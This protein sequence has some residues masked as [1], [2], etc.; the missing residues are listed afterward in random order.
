[1]NNKAIETL[2]VNAVKNSIVT[3][4]YLDEFIADND[5]EPSWDGFIYIYKNKNK[6]KNDIIGRVPVQVKGKF[7]RE[8]SKD[9][10]KYSVS[11]TDLKNYLNDGIFFFVVYIQKQSF[12]T[13]IYYAAL[14]PM[15]VKN[16]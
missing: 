8:F 2:S 11:V 6:T 12:N 9:T 14:S 15:E 3:S 13:H 5:K 7:S 1:M 16:I 4:E 10:I